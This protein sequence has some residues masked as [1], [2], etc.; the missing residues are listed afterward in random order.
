MKSNL[1]QETESKN[2]V[3]VA[4]ELVSSE[5]MIKNVYRPA[6]LEATGVLTSQLTK[7]TMNLIG[8]KSIKDYVRIGVKAEELADRGMHLVKLLK[9]RMVE[10]YVNIKALDKRKGIKVAKDEQ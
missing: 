8:E 7:H 9:K 2:I 4:W 5:E 1:K 3:Q 6:V 10:D